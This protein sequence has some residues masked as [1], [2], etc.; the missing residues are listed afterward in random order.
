[1]SKTAIIA[2][3]CVAVSQSLIIWI[4]NGFTIFVFWIHRKRLK[5]TSIVLINLAVADLLVGF[6]DLLDSAAFD[7]PKQLG[8]V[9]VNQE[10]HHRISNSLQFSFSVTSILF[11]ALISLE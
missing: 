6:S 7:L 2:V 11:L 9:I 4:G 10:I 3:W 8:R 1:M 5:R